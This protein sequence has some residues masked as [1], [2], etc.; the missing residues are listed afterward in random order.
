MHFCVTGKLFCILFSR[1]FCLPRVCVFA[2]WLGQ[3]WRPHRQHKKK[4]E[5]TWTTNKPHNGHNRSSSANS[6]VCRIRY[7][8]CE[9]RPCY[10]AVLSRQMAG[11]F[12]SLARSLQSG[13]AL[14]HWHTF[15]NCMQASAGSQTLLKAL[16][17]NATETRWS[18]SR[19]L[20]H[21][22]A[23]SAW[24]GAIR[25]RSNEWMNDGRC[26]TM[27]TCHFI[28]YALHTLTHIRTLAYVQVW[29]W[30]RA[31]IFCV[32]DCES[33]IM[34]VCFCVCGCCNQHVHV[35]L[36]WLCCSHYLIMVCVVY[37]H[38]NNAVLRKAV[39]G[40]MH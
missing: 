30:H 33:S 21:S 34:C 11:A 7:Q 35:Q 23:H 27:T 17:Q 1:Y 8:M 40:L 12:Y 10:R 36:L 3:M 39:P 2:I 6:V 26:Y 24:Y 9:Y 29:Q 22:F 38:V 18:L 37:V 5:C 13:I 31:S 28:H 4:T 32:G 25:R 20:S 16:Q 15:I 19:S 14:M